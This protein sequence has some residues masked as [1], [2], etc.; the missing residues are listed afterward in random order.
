[1]S[2]VQSNDMEKRVVIHVVTGKRAGMRKIIGH[3]V[4]EPGDEIP[5]KYQNV[6]ICAGE[7]GRDVYRAADYPNYVLF[8]EG[9][10]VKVQPPRAPRRAKSIVDDGRNPAS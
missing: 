1:M 6:H 7:P 5:L 8:R 10:P 2:T 3:L 4:L 9:A